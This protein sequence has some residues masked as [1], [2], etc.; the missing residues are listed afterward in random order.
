E[1]VE[2]AV[3]HVELVD[4]VQDHLE[5][6]CLMSGEIVAWRIEMPQG[7]PDNRDE[8]RRSARIARGEQGHVVTAPDEL[9][10]QGGDDTFGATIGQRRNRLEW[11]SELSDAQVHEAVKDLPSRVGLG[12]RGECTTRARVS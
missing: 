4:P 7:P 6:V 2:M 11:R 5:D 10:R 12:G 1:M 9:L 3:D 8:S